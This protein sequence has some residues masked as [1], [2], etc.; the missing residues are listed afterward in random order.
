MLRWKCVAVIHTSEMTAG[1]VNS[2]PVSH[3]IG[4]V[5]MRNVERTHRVDDGAERFIH[6]TTAPLFPEI[7]PRHPK[8]SQDSRPVE[9]LA[10]A[11][12]AEAHRHKY[13]RIRVGA[14]AMASW[15]ALR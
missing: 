12:L 8:G 7:L 3:V 9:T 4:I 11:M 13:Y 5:E 6:V 14:V 15:R 10:G 2:L 1:S